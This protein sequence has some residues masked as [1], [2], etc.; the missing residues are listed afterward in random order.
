MGRFNVYKKCNISFSRAPEG[1]HRYYTTE[2]GKITSLNFQRVTT[3]PSTTDPIPQNTGLELG[4][5][6]LVQFKNTYVG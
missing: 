1:C 2:S 3:T 5:Q 6:R 4:G